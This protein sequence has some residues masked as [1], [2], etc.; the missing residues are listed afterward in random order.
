MCYAVPIVNGIINAVGYNGGNVGF[1]DRYS[2]KNS[3]EAI[4][5]I[6]DKTYNDSEH[7]YDSN[8]GNYVKAKD[9]GDNILL[10][11]ELVSKMQASASMKPQE[12]QINNNIVLNLTNFN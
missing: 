10:Y 4:R 11:K 3:R 6:E 2:L 12:I 5:S 9:D 1:L 8:L 7:R